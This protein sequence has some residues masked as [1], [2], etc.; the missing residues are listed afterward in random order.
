[1][2]EKRKN[3][4]AMI[5]ES[6]HQKVRERQEAAGMKLNDYVTWM[7]EEFYQMEGKTMSAGNKKTVAFQVDEEI[8]QKFKEYL[9]SR[10]ISQ[11]AFFSGCIKEALEKADCMSLSEESTSLDENNGEGAFEE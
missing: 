5:P 8:F 9:K 10:G 1:M 6:L 11:T 4:C 7:I 2:E 3:L